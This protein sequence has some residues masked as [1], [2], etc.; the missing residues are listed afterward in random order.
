MKNFLK[1]LFA[2]AFTV[3]TALNT[4]SFS[5]YADV[6]K[7]L[8]EEEILNSSVK[9]VMTVT[10]ELLQPDG[11]ISS[12]K[13]NI[14]VYISGADK[15]YAST[16]IHLFYDSRLIPERDSDGT[17]VINNYESFVVFEMCFAIQSFYVYNWYY[18]LSKYLILL[19]YILFLI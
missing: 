10:K 6:T 18:L 9:P 1:G 2:F 19:L 5:A 13:M 14:S 4:V 11:N 7:G 3:F 8:S 16:G 17:L 12:R 15:K